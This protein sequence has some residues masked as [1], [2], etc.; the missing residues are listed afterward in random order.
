MPA[1]T[2]L[3]GLT[4]RDGHVVAP[5]STVDLDFAGLAGT[6]L[7]PLSPDP[8][9]S[10]TNSSVTVDAFGRV[11][12]A[13]S[14]SAGIAS[15]WE[16]VVDETGASFANFTA[17]SGT[18][19]SDGTRIKQTDTTATTRVAKYNTPV[20]TALV[21]VQATIQIRT[22][23]ANCIGGILAGFDGSAAGG[24]LLRIN[25]DGSI[26]FCCDRVATR[27]DLATTVNTNT[28]YTIRMLIAG[29]NM[30]GYKDGS[31]VGSAG[32]TLQNSSDATYVGLFTFGAEVWFTNFKVWTPV[33]P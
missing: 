2:L 7:S 28:D 16:K 11:T 30:T 31:L 25:Q 17:A 22:A 26:E 3:T 29:T 24:A 5:P 9:G 21:I 10:Y 19:T 8:S 13:S 6:T 14:G 33:M 4:L 1:V 12:A 23:G 27:L 15:A 32:N 20:I 18:W